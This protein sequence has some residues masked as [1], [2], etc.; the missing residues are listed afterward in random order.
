MKFQTLAAL[1]LLQLYLYFNNFNTK[2][3]IQ[4]MICLLLAGNN[5][6]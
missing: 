4:T 2:T 1:Y 6:Q 3:L 5:L